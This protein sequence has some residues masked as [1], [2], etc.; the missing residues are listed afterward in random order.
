M[1]AE[2]PSRSQR[3]LLLEIA[4]LKRQLAE[5]GQ[6]NAHLFR[7]ALAASVL[8]HVLV[9]LI[10]AHTP[11]PSQP[12]SRLEATL[13]RPDSRPQ[14]A[15]IPTPPERPRSVA[16]AP[17]KSAQSPRRQVIAVD[18]SKS[19]AAAS[20][21][22]W[23][24]AQKQ[25][26]DSFLRELEKQAK[27]QP[28]PDLSQRAL[29]TARDYARHTAPREQDGAEIL[30]RIPNAP[31]VEPF[32]LEMYL[33]AL[34]KKLNRSAGFVANDPRR[35]GIRRASVQVTLNPDGSMRQFRIV[36]AGDQ[37]PQ[38]DYIRAVVERAV[39][40]AAFPSDLKRSASGLTMTI[41]IEPG[42]GDGG[43]GFSRMPEGKR[44]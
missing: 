1:L 36:N 32:S 40:F 18:K 12:V 10:P 7:I 43:L 15:S 8:L 44:C 37:Q 33:D 35:Q 27:S 22:K 34:V 38:I 20:T 25:E 30:E 4:E 31:P 11:K 39:P 41:C 2:D 16:P 14:T 13:A 42:G 28:R 3:A 26:M 17:P 19:P 23:T 6:R 24:V 21:P 9:L 29:A 5:K